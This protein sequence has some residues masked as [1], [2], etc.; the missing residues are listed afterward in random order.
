MP[1]VITPSIG[2]DE[3]KYQLAAV[4]GICYKKGLNFGKSLLELFLNS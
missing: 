1:A 3:G 4:R 2:S